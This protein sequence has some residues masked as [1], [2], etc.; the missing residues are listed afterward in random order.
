MSTNPEHMKDIPNREIETTKSYATAIATDLK[1]YFSTLEKKLKLS[2][3]EVH[4]VNERTLNIINEVN[5]I[6]EI[7]SDPAYRLIIE[8][9][10]KLRGECS[11]AL[12]LCIDGRI[13]PLAIGGSVATHSRTGAGIIPTEKSPLDERLMLKSDRI[14]IAVA[15]KGRQGKQMLQITLGHTSHIDPE[16]H[17]CGAMNDLAKSGKLAEFKAKGIIAN[18]AD[19][20]NSNLD[21]FDNQMEAIKNH[22]NDA[23]EA[24]GHPTLARIGIKGIYDTDHMGIVFHGDKANLSTVEITKIIYGKLQSL[25]EEQGDETLAIPGVMRNSFAKQ[26]NALPIETMIYNVTKKVI[27][28]AEFNEEMQKYINLELT[29]MTREQQ[30]TFIFY[31]ARNVAFQ[32]LTGLF[33][34]DHPHHPLSHHGENFQS[35][36]FDGVSVGQFYTDSQSFS[37]SISTVEEAASHIEI[38]TSI[39]NRN[40]KTKPHIVFIA[41]PISQIQLD[42]DNGS[43]ERS[44]ASLRNEY[45]GILSNQRILDMVKASEIILIPVFIHAK[46]RAIVKI[47]NLAAA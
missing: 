45:Y 14:A 6:A 27:S 17:G 13:S 3:P 19:I 47:P 15:E 32:Y 1:T 7:F 20:I 9:E 2:P 42:E 23:A 25:F 8:R 38:Q 39:M 33:L 16:N 37:S 36:S 5:E 40:R 11:V 41:K 4:E 43:L 46:T 30:K 26:E 22:Y 10:K 31:T 21:L 18:D 28:L 24:S 12:N 44:E 35:V 34:E 29:D